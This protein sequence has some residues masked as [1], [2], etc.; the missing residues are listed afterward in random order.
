MPDLS[1]QAE[2]RLEKIKAGQGVTTGFV[3]PCVVFLEAKDQRFPTV[4]A[5]WARSSRNHKK[6]GE[7]ALLELHAPL[8]LAWYPDAGQ[9]PEP[10]GAAGDEAPWLFRAVRFKL[11]EILGAAPEVR[12]RAPKENSPVVAMGLATLRGHRLHVKYLTAKEDEVL[13]ALLED[14]QDSPSHFLIDF[15]LGL[16]RLDWPGL[17]QA[18]RSLHQGKAWKSIFQKSEIDST[19]QTDAKIDDVPLEQAEAQVRAQPDEG[20]FHGELGKALFKAGQYPRALQELQLGLKQPGTRYEILNLMG[21][22][23]L[24]RGMPDLAVKQLALAESE[25][26]GMDEMK[27]EII[28]NLGLAYEELKQPE[29]ALEQWRKIYEYEMGYRDVARRMEASY[30]L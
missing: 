4:I 7:P 28:Y 5:C 15:I 22:S 21:L 11:L 19:L 12:L 13:Q 26:P 17:V 2:P 30:R 29:R 6:T 10:R 25:L 23:F 3:D 20:R 1:P 9:K 27:K 8:F 14:K 18:R 16:D 24:K